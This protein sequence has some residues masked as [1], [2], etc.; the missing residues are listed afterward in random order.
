MQ[1]EHRLGVKL[2]ERTTR[3]AEPTEKGRAFIEQ[4]RRIVTDVDNR[5]TNARA[6]SY[7]DHG[8]IAAGYCSSLMAGHLKHA[9]SD[10]LARYPD[11]QFDG[12][13]AGQGEMAECLPALAEIAGDPRVDERSR[14]SSGDRGARGAADLLFLAG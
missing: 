12:V 14:A 4:A 7:G 5:Q 3:G 9:F 8:R 10:Y 6:V 2:F 11:V 1:L 13:E